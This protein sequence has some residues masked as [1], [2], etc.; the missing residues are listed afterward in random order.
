M[1]CAC[2]ED[3]LPKNILTREEMVDILTDIYVAE[4]KIS[5]L[6]LNRDSAQVVYRYYEDSIFH[7]KGVNDSIY[8]LSLNYY[9]QTPDELDK[10]YEAVLDSLNLKKQKLNKSKESTDPS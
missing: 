6:S 10:I 7:C 1:V 5:R 9:M 8:N 2:G 4:A 3:E